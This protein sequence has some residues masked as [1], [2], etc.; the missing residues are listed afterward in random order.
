MN[1]T[2]K[3]SPVLLYSTV[4][5]LPLVTT[6]LFVSQ[7]LHLHG[8]SLFEDYLFATRTEPSKGTKADILQINRFSV[9]DV[10]TVTTVENSVGIR[11]YQK[12]TQPTGK[13]KI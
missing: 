10:Q 3:C 12:L 5:L 1:E 11:V 4:P 13:K 2:Y 7:L 6:A 9:A 8:L